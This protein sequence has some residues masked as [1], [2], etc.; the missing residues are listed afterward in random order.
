MAEIVVRKL[1]DEVKSALK[2]RAALNRRSMEAEAR[3]ILTSALTV[4]PRMG[5]GSEIAALFKDLGFE[6]GEFERPALPWPD[7]PDFMGE[8]GDSDAP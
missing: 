5:L 4:E 7:P 3:A 6:D 2:R 1:S 8:A